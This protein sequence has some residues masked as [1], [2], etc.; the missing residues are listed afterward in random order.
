MPKPEIL[1]CNPCLIKGIFCGKGGL[2]WNISWELAAGVKKFI[3]SQP[4]PLIKEVQRG[5]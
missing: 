3:N 1:K 4:Q 5:A 2:T